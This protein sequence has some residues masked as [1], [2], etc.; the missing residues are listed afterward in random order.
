MPC[1]CALHVFSSGVPGS[2]PKT[3]PSIAPK[4]WE[5]CGLLP[6]FKRSCT[7]S[8]G[9]SGVEEDCKMRRGG[10]VSMK[11]KFGH[12]V[13]MG[14]VM[15]AIQEVWKFQAQH[16]SAP[17]LSPSR[18]V[19]EVRE[20]AG[21]VYSHPHDCTTKPPPPTKQPPSQSTAQRV[22]PEV[23]RILFARPAHWHQ[24]VHA[25]RPSLPA[26]SVV[27]NW[28]RDVE[29]RVCALRHETGCEVVGRSCIARCAVGMQWLCMLSWFG[30]HV[31]TPIARAD[32]LSPQ[33]P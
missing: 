13:M 29:A 6:L 2:P 3:L 32:S 26:A 16:F 17:Q 31:C 23:V 20:A 33:N 7:Q 1:A 14:C 21:T 22:K 12:C 24:D 18:C 25:M 10:S 9:Q 4:A 28:N 19:W 5:Q 15:E 11:Q 30:Y 8:P 27:V